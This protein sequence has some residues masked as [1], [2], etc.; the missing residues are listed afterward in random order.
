[1]EKSISRELLLMISKPFIKEIILH[2]YNSADFTVR[3]VDLVELTKQYSN[4]GAFLK[5][6][7]EFGLIETSSTGR[8]VYYKLIK[9]NVN[10]ILTLIENVEK[11][12]EQIAERIA[13]NN[14]AKNIVPKK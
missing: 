11:N 2:L 12:A 1:M 4:L 7:Q 10:P 6:M 3:Q 9:E 14:S 5:K 8:E 13:E